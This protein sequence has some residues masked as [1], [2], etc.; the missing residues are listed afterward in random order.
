[1][2]LKHQLKNLIQSDKSLWMYPASDLLE[3]HGYYRIS[4]YIRTKEFIK[5]DR[6]KYEILIAYGKP[7]IIGINYP[8]KDK[9]T[10][11]EQLIIDSIE[12]LQKL[13]RE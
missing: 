3:E 7:I 4:E 11:L 12:E 9:I 8:K 5:R 13:M 10:D 2:K 1:M 6:D